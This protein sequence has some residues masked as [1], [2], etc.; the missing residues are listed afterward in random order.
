M[1]EIGYENTLSL[2]LIMDNYYA[3]LIWNM[4][5]D[6]YLVASNLSRSLEDRL[7]CTKF[8]FMLNKYPITLNYEGNK[9]QIYYVIFSIVTLIKKGYGT[10]LARQNLIAFYP[11]LDQS[12]LYDAIDSDLFDLTPTK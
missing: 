9:F 10:E 6:A 2:F 3:A 1:V 4:A 12:W 8:L 5:K 11:E 7:A